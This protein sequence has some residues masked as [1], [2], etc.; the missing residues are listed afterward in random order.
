MII[1]LLERAEMVPFVIDLNDLAEDRV[2]KLTEG[3]WRGSESLLAV[4]THFKCTIA[5]HD[6]YG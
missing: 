2:L 1:F 6:V 4:S 3:D 5:V